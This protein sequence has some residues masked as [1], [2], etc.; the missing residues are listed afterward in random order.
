MDF[1][2]ERHERTTY[3]YKC[4]ESDASVSGTPAELDSFFGKPLSYEPKEHIILGGK[5]YE[6]AGFEPMGMS[7]TTKVAYEQNGRKAIRV[8]DPSGNIQYRS[9]TK[10]K[11][12]EAGSQKAEG[13]SIVTKGFAEA[14]AKVE[15]NVK[16]RAMN[17][18]NKLT[19]RR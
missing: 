19:N 8:V 18:F 7:L 11:I 15:A 6:Y 2:K 17:Y 9:K 1:L 4:Y 3:T 13:T 12:L 14:K 16:S 10:D 5:I